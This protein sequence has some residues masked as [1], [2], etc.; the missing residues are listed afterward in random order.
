MSTNSTMESIVGA[1]YPNTMKHLQ[2]LIMDAEGCA[3]NYGKKSF[4]G[5]DK[6]K[7]ALEKFLE[8]IDHCAHALIMDGIV[9]NV[10]D[11]EAVLIA[12]NTAI[13]FCKSAYGNWPLAFQF[14]T[15]W[16]ESRP[17]HLTSQNDFTEDARTKL[18][19]FVGADADEVKIAECTAIVQRVV[20]ELVTTA[21]CRKIAIASMV[22][23][24]AG[25]PRANV[26]GMILHSHGGVI[27]KT[28]AAQIFDGLH[29]N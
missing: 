27:S 16:Y 14:W 26:V 4:F 5:K 11:V 24:I 12:L 20:G 17:K 1:M 22:K 21:E 25:A 9:D 3:K 6:F 29:E 13:S 23:I 18:R 19:M 10:D 15:V 7:P 28:M 2:Q 8:T